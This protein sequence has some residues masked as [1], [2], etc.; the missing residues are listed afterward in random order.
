M[1]SHHVVSR[2]FSFQILVVIFILQKIFFMKIV[3]AIKNSVQQNDIV[4]ETDG[5]KKQ[6][7]I[8]AKSAGQ[9]SSVNGGELLLLSLATCFC[10]DIYREAARRKINIKS[11]EVTVSGNFEKEGEPAY[12]ISY[13]VN[14]QSNASQKEVA[15][16]INDVDKIAEVH[17]T[18]R[19][20]VSVS[21]VT[22]S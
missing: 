15:A 2:Q 12:N 11:V 13:K 14:I 3:A 20:G 6:I 8:P 22:N 5:N 21:L 4:I 16:L 17:N 18:L 10:N 19:K 7:A 1:K 9:G